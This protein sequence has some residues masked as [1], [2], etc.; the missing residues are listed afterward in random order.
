MNILP[1]CVVVMKYEDGTYIFQ[2]DMSDYEEILDQYIQQMKNI[3]IPILFVKRDVLE[4][5][6]TKRQIY[7]ETFGI[8]QCEKGEFTDLCCCRYGKEQA[9]RF[10]FVL[11]LE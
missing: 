6:K 10:Q 8:T 11:R 2:N 9:F 5:V 1:D 4:L 7:C 3:S